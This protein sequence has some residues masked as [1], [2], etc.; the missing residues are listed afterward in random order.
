MN[1]STDSTL[2]L[3]Q[4][5]GNFAELVAAGTPTPGGGSVAAYC[6][7]L[8]ASLGRMMC[9]I[10][11]GKPKYNAVENRLS[12][13]AGN[14]EGLSERLRE[15]IAEDADSFEAVLRAYR[16]PK[17][18]EQEKTERAAAIQISLQTAVDVPFETA[19]R[20]FEVLAL[21]DEL[22]DIG[23]PNALSDVAVGAQLAQVS[24]RGA[25]YN[26]CVN[27]DSLA[28]RDAAEKTRQEIDDLVRQG[29]AVAD[30]VVAKMNR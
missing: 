26:V 8:A 24:I 15:L 6:G 28:D 4:T 14:L 29:A 19:Q 23:T 30:E 7:M 2:N 9:N 18:T 1:E 5:I 27:L 21:L 11:M 20:S 13:I 12:E 16:M 3:S 10:T 17:E 22:A 25:S